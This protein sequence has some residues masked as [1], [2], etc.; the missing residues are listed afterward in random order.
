MNRLIKRLL[1]LSIITLSSTLFYL[2]G[3]TSP[4]LSSSIPL[5]KAEKRS[6]AIEIKTVG[7]LEASRSMIIASSIK[8][9]LG[10]IID[11]VVDGLNVKAGDLLVKMDP[12]PF[13]EKIE[14]LEG[15]IKEQEAYILGV[16]QTLNWEEV[17]AEHENKTAAFEIESAQ[18]ELEKITNGDGPL[19]SSRLKGAMQKA[20][21][22][23]DELNSYSADL[24][25]LQEQGFLNLSEVKQAQKKLEEEK[26]V[27]ETAKMQY[28]SY[29]NH[30]YPMQIK[31]AET[32]LKRAT[33]KQ[34]E[35][36]KAGEYKIAKS[37]ALLEQAEQ[38]LEDLNRQFREAQNELALTEI[39][40]PSSGMVVHREEYRS[41]QRRK[42]R[43]GDILVKNQPLM[44][45]PDLDSM[46]VKTKVREVD[47]FKIE[48]GKPCT[49]QVDAY[50]QLFFTGKVAAI[51][52][53]A[54]SDLLRPSEE[55]YFEVRVALDQGDKR[56]R[57][58][59]TTRVTIH[60]EQ[61]KDR[62]TAPLHALFEE[63]QQ[64]YCYLF[65]SEGYE[66]REVK[67]GAANEQWAE[68]LGGVQEGEA[69][70]LVHPLHGEE[71]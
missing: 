20:W 23:Y 70:C 56:L 24:L 34:E 40:A 45:L 22:K 16:E 8:G 7:E 15:Q 37:L 25:A 51:G 66:K 4:H 69:L 19:E 9:D 11:L 21:N 35:I 58:G 41:G 32:H 49:I 1:I 63:Q 14:K 67:I 30:V 27:Y 6:F 60:A 44:D 48:L 36:T 28:D 18:L 33:I 38:A 61:I 2:R 52:V 10:K 12:T 47:L 39:R 5:A 59:M 65:T 43:V 29:V 46:I 42:P 53:L 71:E 54:L 26:E 64:L 55:K 13:E 57:P 3:S 31:K 50:P 62:L 17:Q 68:L